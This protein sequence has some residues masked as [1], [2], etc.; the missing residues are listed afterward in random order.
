M[1]H[2]APV[3]LAVAAMLTALT[4]GIV[5]KTDLLK[6]YT[7]T[8]PYLIVLIVLLVFSAVVVALI[9]SKRDKEKEKV[10]LPTPAPPSPTN[11]QNVKQELNLYFDRD[12]PRPAPKPELHPPPEP[13]EPN[14]VFIGVTSATLWLL[15]DKW[16]RNISAHLQDSVPRHRV[17]VAEIKN[18]SKPNEPVAAARNIKAE[19]ILFLPE[20]HQTFGPLGWVDTACNTVE[21][22]PGDPIEIVLAMEDRTALRPSWMVPVNLRAWPNDSPGAT[23][24]QYKYLEQRSDGPRILL[25]ILQ[26]KNGVGS[27]LKSFKGRYLW[28]QKAPYPS[29]LI[30]E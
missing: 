19:F 18:A 28:S 24:L 16:Y 30:G 7:R 27:T 17:I 25:N 9:N 8:T 1:K 12:T 14:I 2:I 21:I 10:A 5:G 15:G 23:K 22:E 6:G 4:L 13:P 20:R 3:I 11:T 26:I 29:F